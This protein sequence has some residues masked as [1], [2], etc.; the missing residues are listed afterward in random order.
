MPIFPRLPSIFLIGL[1]TGSV[2]AAELPHRAE[3][4]RHACLTKSEQRAAVATRRAISLA[5][6]IKSAHKHSKKKSEVVRARLC[7]R[8]ERLVYVLTLLAPNGKVTRANIDAANGELIKG[9]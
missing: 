3:L 9:R 6:A 8:G 1:M 5:E 4:A 7:R 2:Q